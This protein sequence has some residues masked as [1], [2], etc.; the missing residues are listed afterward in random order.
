MKKGIL[1]FAHNTREIDY[2]KM[3]IASGGLATK[4]LGVPATLVTDE[5]TQ[6]WM[7]ESGT[8]EK[9]QSVFENIVLVDRPESGKMRTHKD[10][11]AKFVSQWNNINRPNAWNVTP[12]DRTLL[13]DCDYFVLGDNLNSYWDVDSDILIA[14]EYNDIYNKKRTGFLDKYTSA[15]GVELLWATTVMFTKNEYTKTFFDLVE[16]IR[17]NYETFADLFRFDYRTYRND[18]SFSVAY[19]ILNGFEKD[20]NHYLPGVLSVPNHDMLYDVKDGKFI[21]LVSP[22]KDANYCVA[23]IKEQDVHIMNKASVERNI[24]KILELV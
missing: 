20:A 7:K 5:S 16:H 4:N 22:M 9:A 21:F 12:Y 19:H 13:L 6:A 23:S 11:T 24:D 14:E 18:I 1:I 15:E 2:A 10:G 17:Q 8:F 3:A